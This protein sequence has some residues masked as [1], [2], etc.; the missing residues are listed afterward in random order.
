MPS[1]CQWS[2]A[3][4][5]TRNEFVNYRKSIKTIQLTR[6]FR[7]NSSLTSLSQRYKGRGRQNHDAFILSQAKQVI[8]SSNG[9]FGIINCHTFQVTFTRFDGINNVYFFH[10]F[11]P[12]CLSRNQINILV[13]IS[14]SHCWDVRTTYDDAVQDWCGF[15]IF[16]QDGEIQ[17][18]DMKAFSPNMTLELVETQAME[19]FYEATM[20]TEGTS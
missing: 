2:P 3:I 12:H 16:I 14:I 13:F 17:K 8:V 10:G 5:S 19:L 9:V 15:P 7:K 20:A 11:N 1:L 18:T 4:K 6:G